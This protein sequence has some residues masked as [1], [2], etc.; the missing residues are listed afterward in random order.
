MIEMVKILQQYHQFTRFQMTFGDRVTKK[1]AMSSDVWGRKA[2]RRSSEIQKTY[3][4]NYIAFQKTQDH[5]QL[6]MDCLER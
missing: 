4:W 1:A 3:F 6:Y 5:P 2:E